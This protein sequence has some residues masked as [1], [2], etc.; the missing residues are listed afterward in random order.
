MAFLPINE[1]HYLTNAVVETGA[2]DVPQVNLEMESPKPDVT[3]GDEIPLNLY[4]TAGNNKENL[5]GI[6]I[7]I[8]LSE[9]IDSI[10]GIS[11]I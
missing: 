4:V 3:P 9:Y 6:K 5:N 11:F 10:T 2:P 1:F 7:N 8:P